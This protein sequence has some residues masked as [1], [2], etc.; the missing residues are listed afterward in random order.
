MTESTITLEKIIITETDDPDYIDLTLRNDGE[1]GTFHIKEF[2][3]AVLN[4]YNEKF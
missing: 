3:E 2:E 1:G 4:F